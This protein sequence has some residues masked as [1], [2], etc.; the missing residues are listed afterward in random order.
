MLGCGGSQVGVCCNDVLFCAQSGGT[1]SHLS[2]IEGGKWLTYSQC[3]GL[4]VSGFDVK[5]QTKNCGVLFSDAGVPRETEGPWCENGCREG[6][7]RR[8]SQGSSPDGCTV[9]P[10]MAVL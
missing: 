6:E 5:G 8:R 9:R 1:L 4:N 10:K 3:N 2:P 7:G